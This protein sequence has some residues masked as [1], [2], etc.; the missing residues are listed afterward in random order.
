MTVRLVLSPL[1]TAPTGEVACLSQLFRLDMRTPA[2]ESL[3]A[4]AHARHRLAS[5]R[6][7]RMSH[8]R[9]PEVTYRTAGQITRQAS[10]H[11]LRYQALGRRWLDEAH[12]VSTEHD[13]QRLGTFPER[14]HGDR[15]GDTDCMSVEKP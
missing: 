5:P 13:G 1:A 12:P 10:D 6:E 4:P 2:L 7:L 11:L 9:Y 8:A 3:Q 15:P 14:H